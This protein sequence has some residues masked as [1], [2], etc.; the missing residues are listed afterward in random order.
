MSNT[1][2]FAL[3]GIIENYEY[4]QDLWEWAIENCHE[5]DI[6]S[7]LRGVQSQMKKFE[8]L[9]CL[10]LGFTLFSNCDNLSKS[11]QGVSVSA[12]EGQELAKMT[13]KTLKSLRDDQHFQL[14]WNKVQMEAAKLDIDP[15]VLP[16]KRKIPNRFDYGKAPPEFTSSVETYYRKSYFESLDLIISCITDRF[17]NNGDYQIYCR[18]Q[19]LLIE[20]AKGSSLEE[21]EN[22]KHTLDFF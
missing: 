22:L 1:M 21:S 18:S 10:K 12:N 20:A 4:L 11:L 14:L 6:S 15:P 17:E 19:S 13:L 3:G 5:T 7:R 9:F 2:D 8:F 16:R